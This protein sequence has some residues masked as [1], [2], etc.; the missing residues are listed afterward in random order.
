ML[1]TIPSA[2]S[3]A[4]GLLSLV[5]LRLLLTIVQDFG[6]LDEIHLIF[7]GKT[8]YVLFLGL[9]TTEIAI[10]LLIFCVDSYVISLTTMH[11]S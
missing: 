8:K 6:T 7:F 3:F 10:D 9:W 4:K 11:R 1:Q 2:E 5:G